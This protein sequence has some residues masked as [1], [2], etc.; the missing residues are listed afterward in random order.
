MDHRNIG[1]RPLLVLILA[2]VLRG[3]CPASDPQI[4][5]QE[6]TDPT[7][8]ASLV[9]SQDDIDQ[10]RVRVTRDPYRSCYQAARKMF[11]QG[12][13]P[14][15]NVDMQ[16]ATL[17]FLVEEDPDDARHAAQ[18]LLHWARDWQRE[19]PQ[20]AGDDHRSLSI[21][22]D[23]RNAALIYSILQ[24]SGVFSEEDRS[25][26]EASLI[27]CASRLME[28][29]TTFNRR[30]YFDPHFRVSN[31]N[32][33]RFVAVGMVASVVPEYEASASWLQH[34]VDEFHWQ[35]DNVVTAG[36]AWPEGTRYHGAV[37]R[38]VVPFAFLLRRSG[39]VDLW[40]NEKFK[41]MFES[42]VRTQAPPD[43][44]LGQTALTPGTFDGNWD[45]LWSF[46]L[47][48]GACG[49]READPDFAGRLMWAWQRAGSPFYSELSPGNPICSYLFT[50]IEIEAVSQDPL[51]SE[52]L[53]IGYVILRDGFDTE[54]ESMFLFNVATERG[55]WHQHFDRGS[56]SLVALNT[57]L[58]VDP[59]VQAYFDGSRTEWFQRGKAHNLVQFSGEDNRGNGKIVHTVFDDDL[60][61][62]DADLTAAV[63]RSYR[64]RI[65][66][67]KPNSF[68]IWDAIDDA[69]PTE[70][71]LHVMTDPS[72]AVERIAGQGG[73]ADCVTFACQNDVDLDVIAVRPRQAVQQQLAKIRDAPYP[74][75]RYVAS[76]DLKE[77]AQKA[78]AAR[79][80][81][82]TLRHSEPGGDYLTLLHA[83]RR[84]D[85]F[86]Q[87]QSVET[88]E[89]SADGVPSRVTVELLHGAATIHFPN[90]L[91][92]PDGAESGLGIVLNSGP[93]K[94]RSLYLINGTIF[95][96]DAGC[97]IEVNHPASLVI[98]ESERGKKYEL[99]C[100][101]HRF[102]TLTL[103]LP[104]G[105]SID[106]VHVYPD[107]SEQETET[108]RLEETDAIR[109]SIEH[110]R[111]RILVDALD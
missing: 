68:L 90:R 85:A 83:R 26:I 63:G 1:P 57:P 96:P 18:M 101:G 45:N 58:A 8:R 25:S 2:T 95:A 104:W 17:L 108:K 9:I 48:W 75:T 6:I 22:R 29:G 37:L 23:V 21:S 62:V 52:V 30:D 66:F 11:R 78:V 15:S 14:S 86:A 110:P 16:V 13:G 47:A 5:A 33:D 41:S 64:R 31:W 60:D 39:D 102:S 24:P 69:S 103:Q 81:W 27:L 12:D 43:P 61:Y 100:F 107:G 28:R 36:G 98:R 111:Y 54:R 88:G 92:K 38:A 53:P 97:R 84:G 82:M 19:V 105:D 73:N 70:Y 74:V 87:V 50:D 93:R 34:A 7:P 109:F 59:G 76:C 77:R 99:I 55:L 65:V 106:K 89:T 44:T 4:N 42:L 49:Y 67:L 80:K 71:Q 72:K 20:V 40:E 79:V 46:V 32:S 51:T 35:M 3:N 56:F 10:L 94:L 91:S